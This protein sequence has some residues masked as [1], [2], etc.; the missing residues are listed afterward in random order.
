MLIISD[1]KSIE[2]CYTPCS[3]I[4][5]EYLKF[6]V[7]FSTHLRTSHIHCNSLKSKNVGNEQQK[8]DLCENHY[9][10]IGACFVF[11][12]LWERERVG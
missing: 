11:W 5:K 2:P 9:I 8:C 12:T 3:L 7:L 1:R 4:K 10:K 6:K